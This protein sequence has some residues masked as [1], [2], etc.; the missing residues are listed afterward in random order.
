MA[1]V[2]PPALFATPSC[3]AV[4]M[5]FTEAYLVL[6]AEALKSPMEFS[7]RFPAPI[8]MA[9]LLFFTELAVP[10]ITLA[11]P[12]VEERLDIDSLEFNDPTTVA[13]AFFVAFDRVS[14]N[15]LALNGLDCTL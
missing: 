13:K 1:K 9:P 2:A 6:Y 15:P 5:S 10:V 8:V 7:M 14:K 11:T 4:C 12:E 3:S